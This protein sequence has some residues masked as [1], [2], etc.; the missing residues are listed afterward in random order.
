M[1]VEVGQGLSRP[2][3]SAFWGQRLLYSDLLCRLFSPKIYPRM[4]C[5]GSFLPVLSFYSSAKLELS[6]ELPQCQ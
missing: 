5:L 2:S 3:R 1:E 6:P 4:V